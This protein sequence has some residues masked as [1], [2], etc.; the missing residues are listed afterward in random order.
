MVLN[1]KWK[2]ETANNNKED[3]NLSW[4]AFQG[5]LLMEKRIIYPEF[6]V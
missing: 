2:Q 4:T 5:N 6:L 1:K 3:H